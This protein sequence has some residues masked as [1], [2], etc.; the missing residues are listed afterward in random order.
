[1]SFSAT[2]RYPLVPQPPIRIFYR[3]SRR[4]LRIPN[5]LVRKPRGLRGI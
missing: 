1:M 2:P 4:A 5:F 3:K